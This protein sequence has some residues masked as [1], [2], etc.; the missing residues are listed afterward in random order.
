MPA[1]DLSTVV[2]SSTETRGRGARSVCV[3]TCTWVRRQGKRLTWRQDLHSAG[4]HGGLKRLEECWVAQGTLN[5]T[6]VC[7]GRIHLRMCMCV[8]TYVCR[9]AQ[10]QYVHVHSCMHLCVFLGQCQW[11]RSPAIVNLWATL[12]ACA[13]VCIHTHTYNRIHPLCDTFNRCVHAHR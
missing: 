13:C 1:A 3:C 8:Y 4:S 5:G 2:K 6:E 7:R 9:C 12:N 11:L 10:Y